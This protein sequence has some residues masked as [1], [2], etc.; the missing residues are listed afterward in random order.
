MSS[1]G[2]SDDDLRRAAQR[3][4]HV[5]GSVVAG[6]TRIWMRAFPNEPL[7]ESLGCSEGA[8]DHLALCLR[9]RAEQWVTDVADIAFAVGIAPTRLEAFLRSAEVLERLALAH[10]VDEAVG[11]L[12]AARDRDETD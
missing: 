3:A 7:T 2:T 6:L 11:Q 8:I 9:P 5:S 10:P 4:A 12:M 1:D